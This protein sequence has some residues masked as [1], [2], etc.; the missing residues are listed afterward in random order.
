MFDF[1]FG[2]LVS[3]IFLLLV[4]FVLLG[5]GRGC[6]SALDATWDSVKDIPVL[7]TIP[8]VEP[9]GDEDCEGEC[10]SPFERG[11]R[12]AMEGRGCNPPAFK[13]KDTDPKN[14]D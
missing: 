9:G 7:I 8:E 4:L 6:S 14:Q 10:L 13:F 1:A 5:V 12:D 3:L 11:R 2:C